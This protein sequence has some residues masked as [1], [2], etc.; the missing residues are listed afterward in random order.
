MREKSTPSSLRFAGFT[1]IETVLAVTILGASLVAVQSNRQDDRTETEARH[2]ANHLQVVGDAARKYWIYFGGGHM[3]RSEVDANGTLLYASYTNAFY[4]NNN[5]DNVARN[6]LELISGSGWPLNLELLENRG[7]LN[8][9]VEWLNTRWGSLSSSRVSGKN[10]WGRSGYVLTLNVTQGREDVARR[11]A[12]Y[13]AMPHAFRVNPVTG[14]L[15]LSVQFFTPMQ[16]PLGSLYAYTLLARGQPHM[17]LGSIYA[18]VQSVLG[19][20]PGIDDFLPSNYYVDGVYILD[21]STASTISYEGNHRRPRKSGHT[22]ITKDCS[23][24]SYM[25]GV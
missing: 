19:L 4:G 22:R 8:N 10:T 16:A 21:N 15:S 1:V 20:P 11:A 5:F 12:G 24:Q 25:A 14:A 17:M 3:L 23:P 18:N 2:L 13:L 6:H 9:E 7:F